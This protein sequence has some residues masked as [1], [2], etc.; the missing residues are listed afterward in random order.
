MNLLV[1][2]RNFFYLSETFVYKQV[3]GMPDDIHITLMGFNILNEQLFP[4]QS[5]KIQLEKKTHFLD[6]FTTKVFKKIFNVNFGFSAFVYLKIKRIL[7]EK[8][9]DLI[10]AHFGYNAQ[11]IYP[12]A[13]KLNIPLVVTF[14]GL[15]ASPNML[16]HK[17]YREDIAEVIDYAKAVIIVSPHMVDTLNIGKYRNK[18]FLIPCSAD[19]AEFVNPNAFKNN[20]GIIRILHSG[21]ITGKKGVPDLIRVAVELNKK[22]NHL[23]FNIVGDGPELELC[24]Q[25]AAGAG[26]IIF[27]GGRTQKEVL[28]FMT[29]TD[30]FVLNSRTADNG[31]MEGTP[32]S[33]QEAMSMQLPVVSTYHAGIPAVI[34]DGRDG[35]LVNERDNKAM[36]AAF[37]KL[38]MS[39]ELR[40]T[41]GKAA[42]ETI[43]KK[44]TV[45]EM[46][47]KLADVYHN[48]LR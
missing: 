42:R 21:R 19:P 5:E 16:K 31:D 4:V 13:K 35:L 30:I 43:E 10:H 39:R 3:T 17:K 44:F 36:E 2:N 26:N 25:L 37:E 8:K 1:F 24:K 33:I 34:T 27:H 23:E 7:K 38:I 29:N 45:Q 6:H 20:D 47:Q 41:L 15:D 22:F 32:V 11:M 9:I 46:N 18:T 12:L 48:S 28:D 40:Y 14:H